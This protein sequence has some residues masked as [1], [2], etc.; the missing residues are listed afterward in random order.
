M[1][2]AYGRITR[3]MAV[4]KDWGKIEQFGS[5]RSTRDTNIMLAAEWNA[6]LCHTC[7]D[8]FCKLSRLSIVH[9]GKS[10]AEIRGIILCNPLV[11]IERTSVMALELGGRSDHDGRDD[12]LYRD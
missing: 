5:I 10:A 6:V 2:S 7:T 3:F 1:K 12:G 8:V 4:V 11:N 9:A